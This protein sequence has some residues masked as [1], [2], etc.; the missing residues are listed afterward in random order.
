M[1]FDI[2]WLAFLVAVVVNQVLGAL[3]YGP[4]LGKAWMKEVGKTQEELGGGGGIMYLYAIIDGALTAFV[5][6]NTLQAFAPASL[7]GAL[8]VA[9][10]LWLGFAAATSFTN[11]VFAGR[12]LRLWIIDSGY[13]LVGILLMTVVLTIWQ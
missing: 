4:I 5:L 1:W 11:G 12:S 3:W 10:L 2:N 7:V 6:A 13:H 8:V 9:L